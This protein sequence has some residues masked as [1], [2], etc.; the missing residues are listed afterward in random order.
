MSKIFSKN[1]LQE[2]YNILN[3]EQKDFLE[4]YIKR[5]KK[6][7][8]L[9]SWAKKLG[10]VLDEHDLEDPEVSMNKLLDWV[11]LEYEEA[12]SKTGEM[13]CE[14]GR[15]LKYRYTIKHMGTGKVYRLGIVHLGQHTG[16]DLEL[17][18]Q[19]R[20]GLNRI[21]L[22]KDEILLK[23][24]NGWKLSFKIPN[25][26]ELPKDIELQMN[27]GL[28]LLTSQEK[29]L[30]KIINKANKSL[31]FHRNIDLLE[32]PKSINNTGVEQAV[33]LINKLRNV[34]INELE[35]LELYRFIKDNVNNL[36]AYELDIKAI[37]KLVIQAQSTTKNKNIRKC[38]IDIEFF[39][40]Y[41]S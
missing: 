6:T 39:I 4:N 33:D 25:D 14:C 36:N 26:I 16:L 11:L 19:V 38:L 9:N 40:D 27:I 17:V 13:R 34:E 5:S 22:E 21:D 8:W 1:N 2:A 12:D 31:D 3:V 29:R 10:I 23:M 24:L 15:A 41:N 37:R 20:Q 28:P 35:V 18:R 30:K 32:I 7:Q